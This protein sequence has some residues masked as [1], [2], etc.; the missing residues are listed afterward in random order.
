MGQAAHA[1]SH[2]HG[3]HGGGDHHG[4]HH[5]PIYYI[6]IWALLLVLLAIS[7]LGPMLGHKILTLITAFGV[8]VVKALIVAAFFMH[9]NIEKRYVWYILFA[10][11]AMVGMFFF[12]T[13]ADIMKPVGSNW[14]K[15]SAIQLIEEHKNKP[16]GEHGG[17]GEHK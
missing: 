7:I 13:A 5:G 1:N 2:D 17:G 11:L 15:T 12:G 6:K 14:E 3:G 4:A 16:A 9:L 8:A 10:M